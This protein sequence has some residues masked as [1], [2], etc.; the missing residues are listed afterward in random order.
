MTKTA[1]LALMTALILVAAERPSAAAEAPSVLVQTAAVAEHELTDT[2]VGYG[3]VTPEPARQMNI[4]L[5]RAGRI[6][7]LRVGLGQAVKQGEALFDVQ[8]DPAANLAYAQAANAVELAR[9]ELARVEALARDQLATRSQ[10][11][12]ARKT[13]ADAEAGLSAQTRLG[14]GSGRTTVGAPFAGMVSAL[15][16]AQGDRIAAGATV[17]QLA[18]TD[19]L[20]VQ[21]GI[22]PEDVLRV[23]PGMAVKIASVFD[24]RNDATATARVERAQ[25]MINP[26]T[27]LTDVVVTVRNP[28]SVRLLPGMRVRGEIIAGRSRTLAVPRQAVLK[29]DQGAYLFQVKDGRARRVNVTTG[30]ES[31]GLIGIS[32]PIDA[33]APVVV[34]GNYELTDGMRVREGR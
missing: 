28:Q 15:S 13:L 6:L 4:S 26:Q 10:V 27:Q 5:P 20:R 16:A 21:L 14:A 25:G 3:T 18:R 23:Q 34:V 19:R 9:G 24:T 7:A 17:L 8:T 2:L 29:D 22:E 33:A 12:A 11:E 32:G 30:L 1:A 31:E